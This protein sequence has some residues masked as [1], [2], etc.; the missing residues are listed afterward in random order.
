MAAAVPPL[1][2]DLSVEDLKLPNGTGQPS[3]CQTSGAKFE[4]KEASVENLRPMRVV[5]IGAGFSGIYLNIRFKEWL[6]NVNFITYERNK[7]IG[8]TWFENRYPSAACDI[9]CKF[10]DTLHPGS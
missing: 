4:V 8:G 3:S 10:L 6:R 1:A 9:P 5:V 2:V 7:D